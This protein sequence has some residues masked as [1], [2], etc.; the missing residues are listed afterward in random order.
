M[1]TPI[2]ICRFL[3]AINDPEEFKTLVRDMA[4]NLKQPAYSIIACDH[5]PKCRP[6]T[7]EEDSEIKGRLMAA[8]KKEH[9]NPNA[10]WLY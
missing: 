6:L 9:E 8:I 5:S 10:K 1:S 7:K 4:F 3:K 2:K